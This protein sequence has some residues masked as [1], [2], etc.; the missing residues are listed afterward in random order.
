MKRDLE[1]IRGKFPILQE[2]VQLSSCSQS[3]MHV[4]VKKAIDGYMDTWQYDGMDWGYWME[5]CEKARSKFAR[6]INADSSE[7]AIVSSVSH[8]ISAV[9]T[10]L[11]TTSKKN[12]FLLAE[13]EFPCIGHAALS[14]SGCD[15]VYTPPEL[16]S[17]A[18]KISE[19]TILTSTPHVSFYNGKIQK[20]RE[21]TKLAHDND[22]YMF[23]DAYQ[24]A[25]QVDIDVKALDIDFLAAGMQKYMLGIPGIAFLYVKKEIADTLT[26]RVTGWFGQAN[27]FAFDSQNVEYAEGT[28]RFDTGTFPMIN[29]FAQDA[30][31]DV[32]LDIGVPEIQSYLRE[33][34]QFTIE[35]CQSKNLEIASPLDVGEKGSN[36]AIRVPDASALEAELK[37]RGILLSARNDVIRL[38]PH[39][40][41][42]K[43]DI[44]KAVDTMVEVLV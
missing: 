2:K 25:G 42:T 17:Y 6:L 8:A 44:R 33:L 41:N 11:P 32:I 29:G 31:L 21:I 30:A 12:E 36:T 22:S 5:V 16:A 40:Y 1:A 20:L 37:K 19:K 39:F 18:K 13:T 28:R 7:I 15:V 4:D 23:V 43:D 27:P 9:L 38:A 14:Q 26:P 10:S 3:A 34:S 35:Y 24:S